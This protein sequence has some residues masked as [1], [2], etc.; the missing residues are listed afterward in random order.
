MEFRI[1]KN[2]V[3]NT[4]EHEQVRVKGE[5]EDPRFCPRGW[6]KV[7]NAQPYIRVQMPIWANHPRGQKYAVDNM[8]P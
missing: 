6:A 4:R 8:H 5:W 7:A 1:N 3:S 2:T